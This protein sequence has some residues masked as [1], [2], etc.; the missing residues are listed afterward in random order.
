MKKALL[1]ALLTLVPLGLYASDQL[2]GLASPYWTST[3]LTLSGDGCVTTVAGN[4]ALFPASNTEAHRRRA[5][6]STFAA[7]GG[8]CCW[9]GLAAGITMTG[10]NITAGGDHGTG[11]GACFYADAA[12][13]RIDDRPS[14]TAQR[15]ASTPGTTDGLCPAAVGPGQAV[16]DAGA[17]DVL[18]APCSSGACAA[19]YGGGTCVASGSLTR[20]QLHKA[21]MFLWCEDTSQ[22]TVR[23]ERQLSDREF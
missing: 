1:V 6:V 3:A 18:Y 5:V 14:R 12:G 4:C 19:A 17:G 10:A 15:T 2:S 9:V 13:A 16:E 23:K 11:N 7:S 21:G 22:V 8:T 20:D